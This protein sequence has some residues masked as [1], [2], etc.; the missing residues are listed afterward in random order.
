MWT[1]DN[2]QFL[3]FCLVFFGF[4]SLLNLSFG[5][6]AMSFHHI[7]NGILLGLIS[8][9]IVRIQSHFRNAGV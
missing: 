3:K 4:G 5:L 9:W 8:V 1:Y 6:Y 7:L 2:N